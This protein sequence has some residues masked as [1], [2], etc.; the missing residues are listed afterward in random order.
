MIVLAA[1]GNDGQVGCYYPA[2]N[3]VVTNIAASNHLDDF[4]P[5]SSWCHQVDAIAPGSMLF[6]G[7]A[8][9]PTA[10]I[11]GP[12]PSE[13]SNSSYKAGRGTSFA[14]GFAA[15]IAAL[16]RA[17]HPEWPDSQVALSDIATTIEARISNIATH[18]IISLPERA[19]F[20][21]RVSAL[22]ATQ[23]GPQSPVRG[24]INADGCVD[25]GDLGLILA[26]FNQRPESPG[27][28]LQDIDGDFVVGPSDIGEF[29][30]LWGQCP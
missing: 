18:S 8:V 27:L 11:I 21:A 24:D 29:L 6:L 4:E 19:G 10:S 25:S 3:P 15:G 1:A 9:N 26:S 28:H 30:A 20:R 23:S 17:Q 14:V 2:S 13:G 5:T 12:V 22:L 16:V 7:N